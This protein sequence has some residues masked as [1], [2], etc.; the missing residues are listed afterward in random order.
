MDEPTSALD[1]RAR[2]QLMAILKDFRHTKIFTSHDLDMVLELCERTIILHEGEIKA[3]GPT[4]DIFRNEVLLAGCSLEKPLSMQ[5]CAA[6]GSRKP[7][8]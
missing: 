6:C 3:D 8:A 5:N 2:R 4:V 1:T 7:A